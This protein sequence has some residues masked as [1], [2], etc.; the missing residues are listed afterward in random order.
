MSQYVPNTLNWKENIVSVSLALIACKIFNFLYIVYISTHSN[1][2]VQTSLSSW[3]HLSTKRSYNY[4]EEK[5]IMS[6][7]KFS[8]N[9]TLLYVL[10]QW[11]IITN[12]LF[13]RN[14]H[15]YND[16]HLSMDIFQFNQQLECI[17]PKYHISS[18]TQCWQLH[19]PHVL[20]N[21]YVEWLIYWIMHSTREWRECNSGNG[22]WLSFIYH[23]SIC[24]YSTI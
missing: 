13:Y 15:S 5:K 12:I 20:I 7:G 9:S 3:P 16:I 23:A 17:I 6:T 22:D 24:T 1:K 14:V 4:F 18:I 2:I 11:S 10:L 8:N 21:Q 19:R